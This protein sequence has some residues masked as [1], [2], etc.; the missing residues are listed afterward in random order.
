MG[1]FALTI[2]YFYGLLLVH[3]KIGFDL[4][5][6]YENFFKKKMWRPTL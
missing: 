3:K 2:S 6:K 1:N 4:K 5:D